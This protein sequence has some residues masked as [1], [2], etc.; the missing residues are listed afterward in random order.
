M[1]SPK[2]TLLLHYYIVTMNSLSQNVVVSYGH[3][4]NTLCMYL[5]YVSDYKSRFIRLV[6]GYHQVW[7]GGYY[8]QCWCNESASKPSK[9]MC[10]CAYIFF[11]YFLYIFSVVSSSLLLFFKFYPVSFL[12]TVILVD[13]QSIITFFFVQATERTSKRG[14]IDIILLMMMTGCIFK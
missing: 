2:V 8:M 6:C 7:W 10:I 5:C 9:G 13:F 11:S 4:M 12:S 14:Q 1:P 3:E